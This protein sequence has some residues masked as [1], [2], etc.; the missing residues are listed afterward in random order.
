MVASVVEYFAT[1]GLGIWNDL[2][3]FALG[4]SMIS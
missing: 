3:T 2:P 1:G 4:A